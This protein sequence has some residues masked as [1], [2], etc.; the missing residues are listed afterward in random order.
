[1]KTNWNNSVALVAIVGLTSAL[2][3]LAQTPD[4]RAGSVIVETNRPVPKA[5]PRP[6]DGPI[7][8]IIVVGGRGMHVAQ[9]TRKAGADTTV[10]AKTATPP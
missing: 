5:A 6:A 2:P 3:G 10:P 7:Q 1:M 9:P 4:A 8:P